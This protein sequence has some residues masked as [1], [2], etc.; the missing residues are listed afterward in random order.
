MLAPVV[1]SVLF[2]SS[3]FSWPC[4]VPGNDNAFKWQTSLSPIEIF[5]PNAPG[6]MSTWSFSKQRTYYSRLWK[7]SAKEACAAWAQYHSP[8]S[9][10]S[11]TQRATIAVIQPDPNDD[12]LFKCAFDCNGHNGSGDGQV[13]SDDFSQCPQDI[14]T[15]TTQDTED[16]CNLVPHGPYRSSDDPTVH[17]HRGG[18][19]SQKK[20]DTIIG[21][22]IG[23]FV[24]P[25]NSDVEGMTY[26]GS[27]MDPYSLL[28]RVAQT[29]PPFEDDPDPSN[30]N[31]ASVTP[32]TSGGYASTAQVD[33]LI[34]RVDKYGCGCGTSAY[35]NALVISA[36]LNGSMSNNGSDARRMDILTRPSWPQAYSPPPVIT[37]P[38]V[39]DSEDGDEPEESGCSTTGGV[40]AGGL[41]IGLAFLR[42]RRRR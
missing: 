24:R 22:N 11:P 12:T 39:G 26:K 28:T 36:K 37:L 25:I 1:A 8:T 42:R 33:H 9:N 29:D 18:S 13:G 3:A 6:D 15:L 7:N 40:G 23:E 41:V 35:S 32:Q 5:Y 20:R 2:S 14:V 16:M 27:A 17:Y 31:A 30:P 4:R 38:R 21:R 34:P 19:F 10:W